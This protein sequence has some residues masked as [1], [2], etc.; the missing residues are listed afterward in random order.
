MDISHILISVAI[1]TLQPFT[2]GYKKLYG[3][4]PK[5]EVTDAGYGSY[6]NYSYCKSKGIE[7]ILKY[8]GYEKKKEKITDKNRYQLRAHGAR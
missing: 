6:E 8:S 1:R 7:G 5:V 3:N 2:E 4:Y